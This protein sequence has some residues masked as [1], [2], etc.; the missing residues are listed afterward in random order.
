EVF[1][2]STLDEVDP[3]MRQLPELTSRTSSQLRTI[4]EYMQNQRS[5]YLNLV[6]VRQGKD[7]VE[8][9][10]SNLLVEDKNNDAM[11]YVDYLCAIHRMIQTE[12]TTRPHEVPTALW[13]AR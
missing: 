5:K 1:G 2:V 9:E 7:Q 4:A 13:T 3:G 8:L 12:V 10:F 11:S 6:I